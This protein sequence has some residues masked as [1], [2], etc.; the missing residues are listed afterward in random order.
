M[1]LIFKTHFT[2]LNSVWE[3]LL[4]L[5]LKLPEPN[6]TSRGWWHIFPPVN[7]ISQE[8]ITL[9]LC[10]SSA[11]M[12]FL[13]GVWG[14]FVDHYLFLFAA[15][16][17]LSHPRTEIDVFWTWRLDGSKV[18]SVSFY[19]VVRVLANIIGPLKYA[20]TKQVIKSQMQYVFHWSGG[21]HLS[22]L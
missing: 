21:R 14:L 22:L 20:L 1:L 8:Y 17:S 2:D 11:T 16:S 15:A 5:L 18:S 12:L 9:P 13:R 7:R 4:C 19:L 3:K 10:L 6:E